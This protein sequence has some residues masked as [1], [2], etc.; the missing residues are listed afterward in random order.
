MQTKHLP[1]EAER[2]SLDR[3]S[4]LPQPVLETILCLLPTEDAARTS[5]LSR[6]WRYKWTKIPNL[7]FFVSKRKIKKKQ[8][9]V[10]KPASNIEGAKKNSDTRFKLYHDLHEVMLRRQIPIQEL[11]L[12]MVYL[13]AFESYTCGMYRSLHKLF[14]IFYLIVHHL[15]ASLLGQDFDD[16]CTTNELFKCLPVIEHLTTWRHLSRWL[17]LD[18]VPQELPTSLIHLKELCFEE[19]CFLQGYGL[20]FL[21]ILVKCSP[22]LEKIKLEIDWDVSGYKKYSVVWKE[23]S[24]VWLENLSELEIEGFNNLKPEME[25]VKFILV[26]SPKLKKVSIQSVVDRN[27]ESEML[28]TLLQAPRVSPVVITVK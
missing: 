9:S 27:Q 26:R 18:A 12:S 10:S 19:I 24:D 2:L 21:L 5:I 28:K 22:N 25:F 16:K 13:V 14:Y 23:Y 15:R 6:E 7:M 11:T 17:V 8:R 1:C 4:T 20:T 3:I